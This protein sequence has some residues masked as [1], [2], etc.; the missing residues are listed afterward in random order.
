MT[1]RT[2]CFVLI[3]AALAACASQTGAA[4]VRALSD[5]DIAAYAAQPFDKRAMMF[6]HVVLGQHHGV[7]VSVDFPCGDLCPDYTRRIIH[8]DLPAGTDCASAG[9]IEVKELIPRGPAVFPQTFC[10]PTAAAKPL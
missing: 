3:A 8:Y 5:H 1:V 7:Q 9:G 4:P 10:E 6:K 2:V